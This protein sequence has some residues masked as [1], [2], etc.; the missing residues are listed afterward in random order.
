MT[1]AAA[2]S[3]DKQK[4]EALPFEAISLGGVLLGYL[5]HDL[6]DLRRC[7]AENIPC[8]RAWWPLRG[9]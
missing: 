8:A 3:Q 4:V 9:V 7:V 1:T 6:P 2:P 5:V